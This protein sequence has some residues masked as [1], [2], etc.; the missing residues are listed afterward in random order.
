MD[1]TVHVYSGQPE[2]THASLVHVRDD[3]ANAGTADVLFKKQ[4]RQ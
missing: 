2:L 4:E 1:E 3:L